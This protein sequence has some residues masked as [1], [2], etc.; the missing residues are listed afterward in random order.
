M[1]A[2]PDK[3][4]NRLALV[5]GGAGGIGS[6]TCH[7]LAKAGMHVAVADINLARAQATA[8]KLPGEGHAAHALDVLR[9]ESVAAVFAQAEAAQGPIT[10]L[11]CVAGGSLITDDYRPRIADMTLDFWSRTEAVNARGTFL[12]VREF[13]RLREKQPLPDGRII[14][15]ASLAGQTGGSSQTDAAYGASKAAI[16]SLMRNAAVQGA[17]L[18]ITANAIAPGLIDTDKVRMAVTAAQR[19]ATAAQTPLKRL[20]EASEVAQVIAFLA[21]PGSSFVTGQTVN[22]NG[23]RFMN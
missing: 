6:A 1:A 22:V 9:E 15:L 17:P 8:A 7:A 23:G 10:V 4:A 12:C 2:T 14:A 19:E 3:N 11:V 18:G 16:M 21:S 13:L 20:G 5:T